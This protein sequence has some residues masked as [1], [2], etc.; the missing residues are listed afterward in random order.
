MDDYWYDKLVEMKWKGKDAGIF[1]YNATKI[2]IQWGGEG[3]GGR[4]IA[5]AI[6]YKSRC[7]QF[8]LSKYANSE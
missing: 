7:E 5:I 2:T 4:G 8:P 3:V 1:I 6:Y